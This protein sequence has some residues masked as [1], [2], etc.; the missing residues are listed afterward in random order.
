[1]AATESFYRE[2]Y[3]PYVEMI[4]DSQRTVTFAGRT[5]VITDIP[6]SA[7]R[8]GLDQR[9]DRLFT[10]NPAKRPATGNADRSSAD[11]VGTIEGYLAAGYPQ[12][13][14][15]PNRF[16]TAEGIFTEA[17]EQDITQPPA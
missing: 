3:R 11:I 6:G 15:D 7:D 13:P 5:Y 14:D 1:M 8:V 12:D 10:R 16:V 17:T 2:F 9:I 4:A